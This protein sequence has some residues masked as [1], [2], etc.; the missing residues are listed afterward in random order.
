MITPDD[1]RPCPPG[2]NGY[3]TLL[4]RR[5]GATAWLT[6]NRAESLNALNRTMMLE[7]QHY[8]GEL[9]LDHSVRVVVLTGGL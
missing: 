6:L 8:F 9:A 3:D 7:L 2:P 1:H 4:V 5:E